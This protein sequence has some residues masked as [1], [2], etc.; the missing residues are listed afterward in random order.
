[1]RARYALRSPVMRAT[2][3]SGS[4]VVV[5]REVA[6]VRPEPDDRGRVAEHEG[7]DDGEAHGPAHMRP[8]ARRRLGSGSRDRHLAHDAH[9]S[10]K[11]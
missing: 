10:R 1:M 9:E 3:V 4:P 11:V 5:R 7:P 2:L 6:A 8:P